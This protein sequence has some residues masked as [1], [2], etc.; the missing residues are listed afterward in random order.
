MASKTD[1]TAELLFQAIYY[2]NVDLL[3]E[4]IE[5]NPGILVQ[6]KTSTGQSP[7]HYA[8]IHGADECISVLC[9]NFDV[10]AVSGNILSC[11]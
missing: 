8:A 9:Q 5:A 1:E 7:L 6:A 10:D 4:L 2:K 3:R 11:F